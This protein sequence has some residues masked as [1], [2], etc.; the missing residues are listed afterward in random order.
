MAC[1][2]AESCC[3]NWLATGGMRSLQCVGD[4]FPASETDHNFLILA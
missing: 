3:E 1:R 4:E 2:V